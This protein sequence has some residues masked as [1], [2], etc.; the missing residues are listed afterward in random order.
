MFFRNSCN[1]FILYYLRIIIT[2][3]NKFLTKMLEIV[4]N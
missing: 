4:D 2:Q 3:K 1:L